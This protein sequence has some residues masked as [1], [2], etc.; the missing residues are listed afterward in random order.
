MSNSI[1]ILGKMDKK[2]LI[3]LIYLLF[4]ILIN[5]FNSKK[6]SNIS[7]SYIENFGGTIGDIFVFFISVIV[8]YAFKTKLI[9]KS[10]KQN[11]LK[12]FGILFLIT[13]FNIFKENIPY[14]LDKY[15]KDKNKIDNSA[16]LLVNDALVLIIITLVTFFTLKYKYYIHHKICIMIIVIIC[17]S[18]DF[19]FSNYFHSNIYTIIS[20]IFLILSD[21]ILYSYL[22]YLIE[23]KYYFYLDILFIS[24]IFSFFWNSLS[25]SVT[26]LINKVKGSN[27]I[28]FEFYDFY[29]TKGIWIVIIRFLYGL[30]VNGFISDILE[31]IILD[32]LTP[33]YIIICYEI[34]KIPLNIINFFD[35]KDYNKYGDLKVLVL[36]AIIILSILQVIILLFYLEIFEFNFCA[37]NKNTKKNIDEREHLFSLSNYGVDNTADDVESDVDIKGYVIKDNIRKS[38]IEMTYANEI[39]TN[40]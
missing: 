29:N 5:I 9:K 8:K 18:L 31:F 14:I 17:I 30:I 35:S 36:I 32:K 21:S 12:D 20:S 1:F 33:N 22:K 27:K 6:Y 24:G 11:Y 4:S 28:F 23:F 26:I 15:N 39:D 19:L 40:S 37:L 10:E 16:Q 25:L 34:G 7:A 3:P 38:G 13:A 2:L